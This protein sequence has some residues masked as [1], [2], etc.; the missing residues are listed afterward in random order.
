MTENQNDRRTIDVSYQT[1]FKA[2]IIILIGAFL[3]MIR[4][5]ILILFV[6]AVL[7]AALTPSVEWLHRKIKFPRSVSVLV[8][9]FSFLLIVS[10]ITIALIPTIVDE[11]R[12]LASS[13][14]SYL[15]DVVGNIEVS[16]NQG[17]V[18]SISDFLSTVSS[19][20]GNVSQSFFGGISQFFGGVFSL[21]MIL[22]ITFYLLI[23]EKGIQK[24]ASM[25]PNKHEVYINDLL[26]RIQNRIGDWFRGQMLL[27][28]AVGILIYIG[29]LSLG[30]K[31]ALILALFAGI[32]EIVP[33]VGPII[34]AIP[35]IFLGFT[36]N[37]WLALA[38]LALFIIVQ[39][40][41][42]NIL[43]P[44][45]MS[46]AVGLDPIIVIIVVLIGSKLAG[47]LGMILSVPIA[48]ALSVFIDDLFNDRFDKE[49]VPHQSTVKAK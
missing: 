41:E 17:I 31:F 23:R 40:L 20:L 10:L 22:V 11:A 9:Y 28:L 35:A 6:A 36:D 32:M 13:L 24:F 27:A 18:D 25:I 38:V 21:I 1:F 2:I 48:T 34:S 19:Q 47:V 43:V 16:Q 44:K 30:V 37:P 12:N 39:Q 45:I 49:K 29:L 46:K 33:Y 15:S 42:N 5:I 8:I 4:D 7:S 3:F 26:G 14:P